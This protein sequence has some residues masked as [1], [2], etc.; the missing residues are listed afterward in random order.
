VDGLDFVLWNDNKFTSS[1]SVSAVPEPCMGVFLIGALF[2]LVDRSRG[3]QTLGA[4]LR[5]FA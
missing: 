1:D 3:L 5:W 4:T 2:G